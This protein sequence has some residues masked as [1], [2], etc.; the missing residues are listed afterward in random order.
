VTCYAHR[1]LEKDLAKRNAALKKLTD[2]YEIA[3]AKV[4]KYRAEKTS[5]DNKGSIL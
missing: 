5:L 3:K 4:R 2:E 1:K